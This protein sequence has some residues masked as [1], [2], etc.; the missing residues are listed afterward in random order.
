MHYCASKVEI[1]TRKT[2]NTDT[3]YAVLI[4]MSMFIGIRVNTCFDKK[5]TDLKSEQSHDKGISHS[6]MISP[7]EGEGVYLSNTMWQGG[8]G[9]F[10]K[11][12]ATGLLKKFYYNSDH[13]LLNWDGPTCCNQQSNANKQ[14]Q[15]G[16]LSNIS[17]LFDLS[18]AF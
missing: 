8:R 16:H 6:K 9:V 1:R 11:S 13:G 17:F 5:K 12:D 3:F 2:P 15:T 14:P 7:R 4:M 18:R 10:T